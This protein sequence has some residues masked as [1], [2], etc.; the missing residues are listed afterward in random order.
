IGN[1]VAAI[2][3]AR[4]ALGVLAERSR[5]ERRRDPAREV[6]GDARVIRGGRLLQSFDQ[7]RP[8]IGEVFL[9]GA[10]G[11]ESV[12]EFGAIAAPG[13]PGLRRIDHVAPAVGTCSRP[14]IEL[15][16]A[17]W[18]VTHGDPPPGTELC[19]NCRLFAGRL[20]TRSAVIV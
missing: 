20:I 19:S 6:Q 17:N 5:D 11:S 1:R 12:V 16:Y 2:V 7:A 3:L 13:R 15:V 9:G 4:D 8:G 10:D 18:F 14:C